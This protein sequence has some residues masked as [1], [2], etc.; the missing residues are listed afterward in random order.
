MTEIPSEAPSKEEKKIN[1]EKLYFPSG[2]IA[3]KSFEKALDEKSEDK[4]VRTLEDVLNRF[5][6][7]EIDNIRIFTTTDGVSFPYSSINIGEFAKELYKAYTGKDLPELKPDSDPTLVHPKEKYIVFTSFPQAQNG[8]PFT[9]VERAMQLTMRKL[10]RAIKDIEEGR[11]PQDFEVVTLGAPTNNRW[12]NVTPEYTG[13]IKKNPYG[14]LG[15]SYSELLRSVLLDNQSNNKNSKYIFYGISMGGNIAVE[16]ARDLIGK[17]LI[18]REQLQILLDSPVVPEKELSKGEITVRFISEG[19]FH[20][21]DLKSLASINSSEN[22]LLDEVDVILR[23]R[24][25]RHVMTFAKSAE[26]DALRKECLDALIVEMAKGLSINKGKND[27]RLPRVS[28]RRGVNDTISSILNGSWRGKA[29]E[30]LAQFNDKKTKHPLGS[31]I[32]SSSTQNVREFAVSASHFFPFFGKK[33]MRRWGKSIDTL[34]ALR[35]T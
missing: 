9:F 33:E 5:F 10:R 4:R 21:S 11:D 23:S 20:L 32:M 14:T 16:T 17:G 7:R 1:Q 24:K 19:L 15:R 28:E 29:K 12:G 13:K 34:R 6:L 22:K 26:Q 2:E 27:S 18:T 25:D 8:H 31:T 3:V 35:Q 30:K